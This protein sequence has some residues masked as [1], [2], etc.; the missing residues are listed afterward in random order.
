METRRCLWFWYDIPPLLHYEAVQLYRKTGVAGII[1]ITAIHVS[2][3]R[4]L[5]IMSRFEAASHCFIDCT[6][7]FGRNMNTCGC[8]NS[9]N[10]KFRSFTGGGK[11]LCHIK[12]ICR[13]TNGD[14]PR[15]VSRG[16]CTI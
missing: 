4:Q 6:I 1:S 12:Y 5:Q 10:C 15:L 14:G 11:Y 9:G 2:E 16:A 3:I 13:L 7:L 8:N